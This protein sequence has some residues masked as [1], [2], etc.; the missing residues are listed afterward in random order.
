MVQE[1]GASYPMSVYVKLK[2]SSGIWFEM[3][4]PDF[5]HIWG[6]CDPKKSLT[7]PNIL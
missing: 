1:A 4:Q 6:N 5:E 3:N 7:W 2:P